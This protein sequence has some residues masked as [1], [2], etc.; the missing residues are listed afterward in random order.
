MSRF[1]AV[2]ALSVLAAGA[3]AQTPP[4]AAQKPPAT[5]DGGFANET[6]KG[7]YALGYDLGKT[8]LDRKFDVLL[9]QVIAGMRDAVG[10][11]PGRM[12]ADEAAV[13]ARAVQNAG[14]RRVKAERA[15][16]AAKNRAEGNA[17]LE[18]N[19]KRPGVVALPS[20]LQYEVLRPGQGPKPAPDDSIRA[21]F[22][23][24]LVDGTVFDSS[25]GRDEA[26][27]LTAGGGFKGWNE[28][29]PMMPVGSKWKIFVP[30]D[31]GY[32]DD[33][34][35]QNIPPGATL[36][37]EVELLSIEPKAKAAEAARPGNTEKQ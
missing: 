32:G 20:G 3:A 13:L 9:E 37:F 17:F 15:V 33:I 10:G 4:S 12:T 21:H 35:A 16:L 19:K 34:G 27:V 8:I 2:L 26:P 24:T 28:A 5:G 23:G 22:H 18:A 6:E 1:V 30:A 7:S 31:L 25:V 29:L 14:A 36:I 11:R